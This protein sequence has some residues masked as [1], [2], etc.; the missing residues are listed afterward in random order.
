[1]FAGIKKYPNIAEIGGYRGYGETLPPFHGSG[2]EKYG[3]YYTQDDM[4]EIINHANR[5]S[6]KQFKTGRSG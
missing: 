4:I 6:Q 5:R 3:G 2:A 1:M